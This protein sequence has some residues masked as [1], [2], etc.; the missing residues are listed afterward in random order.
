MSKERKQMEQELQNF[1]EKLRQTITDEYEKS[2]RT[3]KAQYEEA[4]QSFD[5]VWERYREEMVDCFLE[6]KP[7]PILIELQ[8]KKIG[9]LTVEPDDIKKTPME[10]LQKTVVEVDQDYLEREM[11][12]DKEE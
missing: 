9:M 2:V 5:N 11:I 3:L 12:G 10:F 1:W 7:C 8:N 6:G 4:L